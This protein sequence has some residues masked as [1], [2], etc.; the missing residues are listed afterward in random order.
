MARGRRKKRCLIRSFF[1][2]DEN[3]K[4]STC[5]ICQHQIPGD[6]LGNLTKHVLPKHRALYDEYDDEEDLEV[7]VVPTK[8]RKITLEYD[9]VEVS[10]AWLNLIV[11][12]GRPFTI[13]DSEALKTLLTPIFGALEIDMLTSRTVH[14]AIQLRAQEVMENFKKI[15]KGRIFSLKIDSATRHNRRIICVN[16][17]AVIKGE[18]EIFTLGMSELTIGSGRHTG[19]NIK[20]FILALLQ[21]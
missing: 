21:R 8:K 17:Q 18:I 20:L 7:H 5:Q 1:V 3:T 12:E 6:H 10:N 16:A 19:K 4:V 14:V 2:Y 9:P 15:L 13:L 11:K